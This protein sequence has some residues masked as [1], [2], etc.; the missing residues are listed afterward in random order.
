MDSLM[1]S[2]QRVD[3]YANIIPEG[4]QVVELSCKSGVSKSG[5]VP[6]GWPARGEI[7]FRDVVMK[8]SC[9]D[10]SIKS[11]GVSSGGCHQSRSHPALNRT[12]FYCLPKEKVV[13][14]DA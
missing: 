6:Q 3:Q 1:T 7:E 8:Y 14:F 5:S 12:S 13:Y 10:D 4:D 9:D 11:I 2:V